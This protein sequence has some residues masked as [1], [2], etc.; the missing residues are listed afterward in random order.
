MLAQRLIDV[1]DDLAGGGVLDVLGVAVGVPVE[2]PAEVDEATE[3]VA[4]IPGRHFAPAAGGA[5]SAQPG[6]EQ[7]DEA[8]GGVER[9]DTLV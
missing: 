7:P 3:A 8:E 1:V 4:L 9:L 2:P 6:S 5:C